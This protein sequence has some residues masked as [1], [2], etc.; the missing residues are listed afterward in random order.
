MNVTQSTWSRSRTLSLTLALGLGVA[1]ITATQATEATATPQA[2]TP[3]ALEPTKTSVPLVDNRILAIGLGAVAG[4]AI[5]H[6]LPG[7]WGMGMRAARASLPGLT[8]ATAMRVG[9]A[10]GGRWVFSTASGLVGALVGDWIYRNN[11]ATH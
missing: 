11:Q 6:M 2:T 10:W 3:T 4:I 9:G 7:G 5:Y 1:S 8:G